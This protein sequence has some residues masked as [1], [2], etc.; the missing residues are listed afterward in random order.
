MDVASLIGG[1]LIG[2][3][4]FGYL[5]VPWIAVP[6]LAL[7]LYGLLWWDSLRKKPLGPVHTATPDLTGVALSYLVTCLWVALAFGFGRLVTIII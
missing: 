7:P 4:I 5:N 3:A 2:D 6:I 1:A